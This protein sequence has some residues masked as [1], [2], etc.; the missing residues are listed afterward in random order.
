MRNFNIEPKYDYTLRPAWTIKN[1]ICKEARY[2]RQCGE[3]GRLAIFLMQFEP[4][5]SDTKN[6]ILFVDNTKLQD[7]LIGNKTFEKDL[8]NYVM[9]IVDSFEEYLS[10]MYEKGKVITNLKVTISDLYIHP[11][12][13]SEMCYRIATYLGMKAI[14]SDV[15]LVLLT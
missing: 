3:P 4:Y 2:V 6:P 11:A 7:D 13:S 12:D 1:K 5:Y 8:H 15:N 14:L 9:A 10:N